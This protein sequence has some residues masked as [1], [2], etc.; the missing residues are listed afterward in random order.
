MFKT[1]PFCRGKIA[2]DSTVCP[3]CARVLR[4]KI[5]STRPSNEHLN[6]DNQGSERRAQGFTNAPKN[7]HDVSFVQVQIRKIKKLLSRKDVLV[8]GH[9]NY[10]KHKKG[11][12]V[13]ISILFVIGLI[14]K[15]QTEPSTPI[16]VTPNYSERTIKKSKNLDGMSEISTMKANNPN[17]VSLSNGEILS[18]DL[19]YSKGLGQLEINNGTNLDA[20]AKLVIPSANRS[21]FT[22]YIRA[23]SI[24]RISNVSDGSY[25]LFFSLGNDWD[26]NMRAF[27]VNS[28]YE[29]F[30]ENFDFTTTRY[31]EGSYIR[32][33]Y[34]TFR[35]T[36]NPVIGGR[37]KTDEIGATEFARY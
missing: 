35:V 11:I 2:S 7:E 10:Q 14:Y 12:L 33:R 4:E 8:V 13:F 5:E 37:A 18:Q 27:T 9:D 32:S 36:L 31:R 29:V 23:N 21:V 17:Y 25:R 16:P 3:L 34:S 30:E 15:W 28:S 19:L 6:Q 26:K 24:Y 22:V 20:I 1:C